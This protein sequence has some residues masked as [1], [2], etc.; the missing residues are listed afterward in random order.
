MPGHVRRH[1]LAVQK[2]LN[3][4]RCRLDCG[5]GRPKEADLLC[6]EAV[7]RGRACQTCLKTLQWAVQQWPSRSGCCSG[8]GLGPG[9]P[10]EACVTWT[11]SVHWR[12]LA[13]TTEPSMFGLAEWSGG[14]VAF[15]LLWPLVLV[16]DYT[17]A[18]VISATVTGCWLLSEWSSH[19]RLQ[20]V[21]NI[22]ANETCHS[23]A[24]DGGYSVV[25]YG[26]IGLCR[27]SLGGPT[28]CCS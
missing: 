19:V 12:N 9:W 15:K 23:R 13:N 14:D 20:H 17:T 2:R 28:T 1:L 22:A 6:Q 3:R 25:Y 4:S 18:V 16:F 26:Y 21:T 11:W 5:L 24:A 10:K 8:C 27:H 7:L